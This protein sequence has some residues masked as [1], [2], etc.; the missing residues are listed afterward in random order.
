MTHPHRQIAFLIAWSLFVG[1]LSWASGLVMVP[2]WVPLCA[3]AVAIGPLLSSR[4]ARASYGRLIGWT[5]VGVLFMEVS[6]SYVA[7]NVGPVGVAG[8][9]GMV[10]TAGMVGTIERMAAALPL[11]LT[12]LV[13]GRYLGETL[14]RYRTLVV[15]TLIGRL[16]HRAHPFETTQA[17]I[18]QELRRARR[19]ERSAALM[20][21]SATDPRG[22]ALKRCVAQTIRELA[23]D[24][25]AARLAAMLSAELDDSDLIA[26]RDDSFVI[27]LPETTRSQAD[28]TASRLVATAKQCLGVD[29]QVATAAFP[30]EEV[31]FVGLLERAE[32]RLRKNAIPETQPHESA[33]DGWPRPITPVIMES[34]TLQTTGPTSCDDA[35][36]DDAL[37]DDALV[38]EHVVSVD[39]VSAALREGV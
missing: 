17:A 8:T 23:R 33:G 20:T 9:I 35:L 28:R 36:C 6:I 11:V 39:I 22:E 15:N 19:H 16:E 21:L 12:S 31:T 37:C 32:S 18:Y 30:E 26:W 7:A 5:V 14:Q 38:G 24:V 2:R 25:L 3:T 4:C 34:H 27:L 29:L 10:S 13:W 1:Y